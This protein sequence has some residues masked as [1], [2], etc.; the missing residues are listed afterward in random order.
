MVQGHGRGVHLSSIGGIGIHACVEVD[1]HL[2]RIGRGGDAG[3]VGQLSLN[4]CLGVSERRRRRLIA[5]VGEWVMT[6]RLA[7]FR[8]RRLRQPAG[9]GELCL[10][11]SREVFHRC[12]RAGATLRLD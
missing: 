1:V 2:R 4:H 12:G 10:D 8:T 7:A 9:R 5:E 6:E 3:K 11:L